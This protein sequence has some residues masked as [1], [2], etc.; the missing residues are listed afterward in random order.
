MAR[1]TTLPEHTSIE[2]GKSGCTRS[3]ETNQTKL[4]GKTEIE[5]GQE[6]PEMVS[7]EMSKLRLSDK[8]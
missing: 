7:M 8:T 5:A 2:I 1:D 3:T 6:R 4:P